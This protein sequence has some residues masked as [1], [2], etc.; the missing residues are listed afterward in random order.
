MDAHGGNIYKLAKENKVNLEDIIDYSTNVNPYVHKKLK[1]IITDSINQIPFYPDLLYENL[2]NKLRDIN[3]LDGEYVIPTNG[4]AEGIFLLGRIL[5]KNNI[6]IL[7]PTFSEYEEGFEG[8]NI[9]HLNYSEIIDENNGFV[10]KISIKKLMSYIKLYKSEVVIICNPNNPTGQV[11]D[12]NNLIEIINLLNEKEIFL[13]VDEA[14]IDFYDYNM[15]LV[16]LINDVKYKHLVIIRSLTKIFAIAGL[17]IGYLMTNNMDLIKLAKKELPPWNINIFA[18]NVVN[19]LIFDLEYIKNVKEKIDK[20]RDYLSKK[21]SP[22]V[23]KILP[24][25]VNFLLF[26]S[27]DINI[28]MKLEKK[29]IL[30]RDCSNFYGLK[31]GYY[32]ICVKDR[33]TNDILINAFKEIYGDN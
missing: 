1:D 9:N 22:Y 32:R 29:N 18:M 8:K 2:N 11:I 17:R 23:E 6:L 20:N 12:R 33:K 21:L 4:A 16:N 7:T 31:D 25:C 24:S 14:F 28:K 13:V 27:M 5:N 3:K 15:S 26:Y 30:I 10:N 19:K